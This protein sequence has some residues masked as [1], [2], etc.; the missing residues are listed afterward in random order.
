MVRDLGLPGMV[1]SPSIWLVGRPAIYQVE[2]YRTSVSVFSLSFGDLG[3]GKY[4]ILSLLL[5]V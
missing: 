2:Q 5:L 4:C 3:R 1:G